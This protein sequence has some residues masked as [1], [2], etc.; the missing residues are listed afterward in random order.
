MTS[1]PRW[2]ME[3]RKESSKSC[4]EGTE[5]RE[6]ELGCAYC[7]AVNQNVKNTQIIV[8]NGSVAYFGSV[9]MSVVHVVRN[10][11]NSR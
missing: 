11:E 10:D 1:L 2:V 9:N 4:S 8:W 6:K 7:R 3:V 5:L